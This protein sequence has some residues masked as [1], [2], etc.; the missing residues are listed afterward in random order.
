MILFTGT[1]A[2]AKSFSA[3]YP[4]TIVSARHLSDEDLIPYISST[5]VIIHNAA[6]I[7]AAE[8]S[9]YTD[10]NFL[11]TKRILELVYRINPDAMFINISSMSMLKTQDTYLQAEDMT[12]YAFS[13]YIAEQ[14][15][16]RHPL[17]KLSNVRFSTLFYEDPVRDGLSKLAFDAIRTNKIKVYNNG[18][19]KRDFIPMEI[20]VKYLYKVSQQAEPPR[21]LNIA[22]GDPLSFN[23]FSNILQFHNPSLVVE[24]ISAQ[25][26]EVLHIFS[27]DDIERLGIIKFNIDDAFNNYI[28]KLSEGINI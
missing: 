18:E 23:H 10:S 8:L 17:K 7:Q 3:F 11:L 22:S 24:N 16:L 28:A 4:C 12:D 5:S 15:C 25:T 9:V 20:A 6:V 27:K 26:S 13:K 19:A 1:G 2:L 21:K 14:Y